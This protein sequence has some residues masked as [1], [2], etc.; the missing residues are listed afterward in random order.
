MH[1]FYKKAL[2]GC[3]CLIAASVLFGYI[4]LKQS[5]LKTSLLPSGDSPLAWQAQPSWDIRPGGAATL[6]IHESRERLR[7]DFSVPK[8]VEQVFAGV[9]LLFRDG[10]GKPVHVDL[11]RYTSISLTVRCSPAN[12]LSLGI[13][14]FVGGISKRDEYLS[15][16][17]PTAYFSCSGNESR[18]EL[19]LTRLETPQWWFYMAEQDLSRQ[20][21]K[22][23][24][25]PKLFIG[26]TFQS[27][28]DVTSSVEIAG[29]EL[30]GRDRRYLLLF[31][32]MAVIAWSGF[33]L[34]FFRKHT[35]A[36]INDVKDKLQKDLP[37]VAYQQLSLEPHRDK[38]K[39]AILQF[40]AT[41]Y[42]DA[43]LD[44]ERVVEETGINRNKI[45]DVLKTELGFTFSG[46]LNKL[47]L[48]EA[49]RLLAEK[50]TAT[51][52][53][54]AYS[55]GYGN[56]SYFNKLFKEEY[57]CTPKAFRSACIL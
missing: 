49:A 25:V 20:A 46:Y 41:R 6:H 11:S 1:E 23:D 47:R 36:L 18:V 35:R 54:I 12:T 4:C 5:Y 27:P 37:F 32:V 17:A 3:F 14:T 57:G 22:L 24:K 13:P 44:L 50:D 43:E 33:G 42:A 39:T 2:V 31:A 51:V 56:V 29:L 15:Y 48:T 19:D 45:N 21:Y 34:W 9:E 28:R 40:I 55:V 10:K 30:R 52:A 26:S 38:E 7:F 8:S 53:E 16:R